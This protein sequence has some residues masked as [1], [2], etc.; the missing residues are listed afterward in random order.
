MLM[1]LLLGTESGLTS[2]FFQETPTPELAISSVHKS[3]L[4]LGFIGEV[5]IDRR[6]APSK[7]RLACSRG[8]MTVSDYGVASS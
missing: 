7:H 8:Y 2:G 6:R 3:G 5:K 1:R 4:G